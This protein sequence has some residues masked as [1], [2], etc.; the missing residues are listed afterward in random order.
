MPNEK[1]IDSVLQTFSTICF[2][3]EIPSLEVNGVSVQW[4][5]FRGNHWDGRQTA[6][7]IAR[8]GPRCQFVSS[9]AV[10]LPHPTYADMRRSSSQAIADAGDLVQREVRDLKLG[11]AAYWQ[12]NLWC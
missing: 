4:V 11:W 9:A 10:T 3:R 6:H 2:D 8:G 12:S 7:V 5:P 1:P